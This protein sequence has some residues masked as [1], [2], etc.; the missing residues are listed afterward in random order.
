MQAGG[1]AIG[2]IVDIADPAVVEMVGLAGFDAAFIDME[3][4]SFELKT[5]EEMIR[6]ADVVGITSIVRPPDSNPKTI[7]RILDMGAQGIWVPHI[8]NRKDAQAVVRAVRYPPL[9]DRGLGV[10]SRATRY[11]TVP[12]VDHVSSSN[13]EIMLT[14]LI[15]DIEA[16]NDIEGIAAIDGIDLVCPGPADLARALGVL[17]QQ[18]HPKMRETVEKIARAIREAGKAK[19]S[20]S[21][22]NSYLALDIPELLELGVAFSMVP[23]VAITRLMR[24]YQ[25]QARQIRAK[26]P[27]PASL[28]IAKAEA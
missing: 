2:T 12:L 7:L 10:N 1:L 22:M 17:G 21:Y 11:G 27:R 15:E 13:D 19:L 28:E 24:S 14:V 6:A 4:T 5:V 18:N 3:H 20:F 23:P 8:A 26:L 9:G 16:I 25:E